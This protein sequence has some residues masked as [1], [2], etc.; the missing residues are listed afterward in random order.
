VI[1]KCDEWKYEKEWRK[2]SV[3]GT[4]E[5][6]HDWQVPTPI[7]VFLGSKMERAKVEELLAICVHKKI[8]L[9]QM[10]LAKDKFELLPERL[11][12]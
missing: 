10:R 11:D 3:T 4:V 7:R 1:Y 6:D 9:W 12:G 5:A 8:E 2:V